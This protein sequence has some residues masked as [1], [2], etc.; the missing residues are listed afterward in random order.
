MFLDF[1]VFKKL[2]FRPFCAQRHSTAT[3]PGASFCARL[4]DFAKSC[5]RRC[6]DFFDH[7]SPY[8]RKSVVR[9]P[10][11]FFL[12]FFFFCFLLVGRALAFFWFLKH[13][14]IHFRIFLRISSINVVIFEH[15]RLRESPGVVFRLS[16]SS[17]FAQNAIHVEVL[18]YFAATESL[19]RVESIVFY[20]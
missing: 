14:Q 9:A 4:A 17:F 10:P 19:L 1:G 6:M 20:N 5:D 16:T 12:V 11:S 2:H 18:A 8:A 15:D 3:Q 7:L 13:F